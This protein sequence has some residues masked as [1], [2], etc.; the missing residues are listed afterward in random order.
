VATA[1]DLDHAGLLERAQRLAH[2]YPADLEALGQLALGRETLA[3]RDDPELDRLAEPRDRL[4]EQVAGANRAEDEL[5]RKPLEVI[6]SRPSRLC[7]F[8]F[9][10]QLSVPA[11]TQILSGS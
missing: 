8:R 9:S 7:A 4:L 6:G 11:W 1:L 2:S 10:G 5:G 3:P